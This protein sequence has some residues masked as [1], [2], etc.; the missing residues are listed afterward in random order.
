MKAALELGNQPNKN[1]LWEI[2]VRISQ[3]GKVKRIK[4]N[5]AVEKRQFKSKKHNMKWVHNH[6]NHAKINS[7]LRA[8]IDQYDDIIL[9][10]SVHKKAL[11][12]ELVLHKM[13]TGIQTE[14]MIKYWERKMSQM[15]NYNQ[16]KG[17]QQ[18]L[19]NWN[20]FTEDAKLGDLDFKQ[21]SKF[22]L[23]EFENFLYG[24]NQQSST[25]YTNLKRIRSVFNQA[26]KE[27]VLTP[28]DYV[29]KGYAM[30]K[31]N[32]VKKERLNIEELGEFAKVVYKKGSLHKTVQQAFLLSVNLAGVRI[33]DIL[34]LKW[35]YVK[36]CRISY[37]MEKTGSNNTFQ[38]KPKIQAILDYFKSISTGSIY[39]IPILKDGIEDQPSE[40]YKK[41]I[42]NKTSLINKYLKL[43]AD[44]ARIDKRITTH[45][46]RHT[47]ASAAY[48]KT[49]GNVEFVKNALKH[50]D[51]KTTRIYLENLNDD[52]LDDMMDDV[53][54][55]LY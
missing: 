31:A 27:E 29:F 52:S 24:K 18:T 8:L 44:D 7:E 20:E 53:T 32:S 37:R 34:T 2:Y 49:G 14:S 17:Y 48:K 22:I 21:I 28:G 46:A 25:V 16:K 15:L 33:E 5:I 30:P 36:N 1:G 45:I 41:E 26:I 13:K 38:I 55:D 3:E 43:I 35:S 6:P 42:G 51:S 11:T 9:N 4:A 39:I 54:K 47:F 23:K 10:S 50:K 12:P 40:V 19:N